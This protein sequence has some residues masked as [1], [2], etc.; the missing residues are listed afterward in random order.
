MKFYSADYVLPV[1]SSPIKDGI[2]AVNEAGKILEIFSPQNLSPENSLQVEKHKG[3][4]VPGFVN[5]HCHLELSHLYKKIDQG[6]GLIP[7]IRKIISSRSDFSEEVIREAMDRADRE[8]WENGIVAVGD[9][10]NSSVSKQVKQNSQIYY[11]TFLELIGFNPEKAN[12]V[13]EAGLKLKEAFGSLPASL[14]PHASYSVC[15]E[16][17]KL[18]NANCVESE[19]VLSI[20]NQESEEENKFYR[21]KTGGFLDFYQ[22]IN[23]PIGFFKPQAR[24]SLQSI[25]PLLVKESKVMLV[26]NTYTSLKDIYF[27]RRF[28]KEITWCFCPGANLYIEQRLPKID[29]F[30]FD[31]FN[32]TLGTDSLASNTGLS[33]FNELKLLHE[34]F[35][36][37]NLEETISWA[38]LNGAKALKISDRFG[39]LDPGKTPGLNLI[40]N[41]KGLKLTKDSKVL[42]LV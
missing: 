30:L 42:K 41:T 10:S 26:H 25:I 16:L 9:I 15:K 39:S 28:I 37:I 34:N 13:Y 4:I 36:D 40:T 17:L 31:D 29:F 38:T 33:I 23:V 6:E 21:Y 2:I 11:H 24:N 5:A 12:H 3:L 35:T 20:H 8:M 18:I 14:V 32:I 1:T 7:F 19:C 22:S 27:V